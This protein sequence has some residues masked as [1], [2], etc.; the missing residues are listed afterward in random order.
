MFRFGLSSVERYSGRLDD[1]RSSTVEIKVGQLVQID[2]AGDGGR[3]PPV[4][5]VIDSGGSEDVLVPV[6]TSYDNN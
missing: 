6:R 1:E 2:V 4:L 3:P 5:E